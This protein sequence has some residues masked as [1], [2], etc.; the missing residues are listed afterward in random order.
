MVEATLLNSGFSAAALM[1]ALT[2]SVSN[3]VGRGWSGG[4]GGT[5]F[6][7]FQSWVVNEIF[8]DRK[9]WVECARNAAKGMGRSC[10]C[11][12]CCGSNNIVSV[13]EYDVIKS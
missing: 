4:E 2:V 11:C 7:S 6:F 1:M 12:Y 5:I 9:C 8:P 3:S 13:C 10:Q